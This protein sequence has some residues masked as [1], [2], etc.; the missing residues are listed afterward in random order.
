MVG[1][2]G[3]IEGLLETRKLWC[4]VARGMIVT[5]TVGDGDGGLT[6]V[7]DL[8]CGNTS[9]YMGAKRRCGVH[10]E[11]LMFRLWYIA[12]RAGDRQAPVVAAL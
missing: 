3:R 11:V 4:D 6:G 5:T 10:E 2:V 8:R 9:S 1:G 12:S 7:E